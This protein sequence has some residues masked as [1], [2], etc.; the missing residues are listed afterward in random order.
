[1]EK[2]IY[3]WLNAGMINQETANTLLVDVKEEK[4]KLLRVRLNIC[5]YTIAIVLIGTGIIAFIGANDWLLKLLTSLPVLQ[6]FLM[7]S[8]TVL[9]LFFGYK[10]AYEGNKF[11]KLGHSMIFLSTLLIGGTYALTGQNYH[12][13][14]NSSSLAFLWMLSILPVAYIFKNFAI[15]VVAIILYILGTI[16]YY[17][18]LSLDTGLTWTIFIPFLLGTT[19]YSVGNIPAIIE[20]FNKFSMAY[21]LTGLAPIFVTLLILTCSVER[22]YEQNSPYYIVP[23]V[24]LIGLNF[25]NFAINKNKNLLFK[26]ETGYIISLLLSLLLIITLS[27]VSVPCVMVFANIAIITMISAGFNYGYKFEN[28]NVIALTNCFIIIYLTLNYCR[29]GWDMMDKALFFVLGGI[30]LLALGMFL[31]NRRKKV[32]K[33]EN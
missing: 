30:G 23:I 31:E 2:M 24:V 29:W 5:I 11:P 9:V 33:K 15:N 3:K 10:L 22:T 26:I 8:L 25:I 1:M 12:I 27:L 6:I 16:F 7:L 13:N 14:A 21:K 19:L 18:E 28:N 20:K 17:L 4:A 32:M